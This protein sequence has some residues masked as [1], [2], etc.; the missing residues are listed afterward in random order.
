MREMAARLLGPRAHFVGMV[1][2]APKIALYRRAALLALPTSQENFG[3]VF[4]EALACETP[5]L[6]TPGVDIHRELVDAGAAALIERDPVTVA[7]AVDGLL[8]DCDRRR[9]MGA[10]GRRWVY[11]TLDPAVV[12]RRWMES[13]AEL[14][15]R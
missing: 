6:L 1:K 8:L 2:G 12:S 3:L 15:H 14:S 11:S 9:T 13:Y 7:E 4:A 5:V 10:A